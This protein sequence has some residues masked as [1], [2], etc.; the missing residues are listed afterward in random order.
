MEKFDF[1][2]IFN[3]EHPFLNDAID[4]LRCSIKSILDQKVNICLANYSQN[5]IFDQINEFTKDIRY[6][7]IK[8]NGPF[9]KSLFIN[10]AVKKLI[11]SNYFILS[12]I[13]LIYSREHISRLVH[14][15]SYLKDNNIEVRYVNYNYNL[16]PNFKNT[17]SKV[18]YKFPFR[19]YFIDEDS[20]LVPHKYTHE[21]QVLDRMKKLNGGFAH[22][23]G[24]IHTETFHLINGYDEEMIGHGPEDDL[25]NT[26]IGKVNK[27]IYDNSND[28]STFHLWHP[29]LQRI[30]VEKNLNLWIEKK[31]YLDSL[32][33]PTYDDVKANMFKNQWGVI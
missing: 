1:L 15:L 24:L 30:Q 7:H 19:N 5:C 20:F 18:I 3:Y 23:P 9:S 2:Y 26:R 10:H 14:K 21:Y 6:L 12:D 16:A 25:F 22:G 17:I 27:L 29:K 28:I 31:I 4:R 33:N 11:K 8:Y 13:D 32:I